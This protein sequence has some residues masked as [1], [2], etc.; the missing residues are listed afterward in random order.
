MFSDCSF[1]RFDESQQKVKVHSTGT[2]H[3]D[4]SVRLWCLTPLSTVVQ[5]YQ[6]LVSVTL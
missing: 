5:L 3:F 1:N 2:T 6:S 4:L